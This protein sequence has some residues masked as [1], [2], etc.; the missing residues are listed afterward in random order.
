MAVSRASRL[1]THGDALQLQLLTDLR[2][3]GAI[4]P[5]GLYTAR[6]SNPLLA[7]NQSEGADI[8]FWL[9]REDPLTPSGGDLWSLVNVP[10]T[11]DPRYGQPP[12]LAVSESLDGAI[13]T[14]YLERAGDLVGLRIAGRGD[15]IDIQDIDGVVSE[16]DDEDSSTYRVRYWGPE[17]SIRT[18]VD[19]ADDSSNRGFVWRTGDSVL[20]K[21]PEHASRPIDGPIGGAPTPV[22]PGAEPLPFAVVQRVFKWIQ[23][24][25]IM[26][27]IAI[28]LGTLSL[29]LIARGSGK[30]QRGP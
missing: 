20:Q 22:G 9:K 7:D 30:D 12:D 2:A 1:L 24:N 13:S 11:W 18:K 25:P 29:A 4:G 16:V 3:A 21:P 10:A 19:P 27:G 14:F 26:A 17:E 8:E 6:R 23:V 15:P 5:S 28:G